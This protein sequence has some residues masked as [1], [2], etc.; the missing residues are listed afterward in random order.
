M[1]T[2]GNGQLHRDAGGRPRRSAGWL[3]RAAVSASG[4]GAIGDGCRVAQPRPPESSLAMSAFRTRQLI[5]TAEMGPKMPLA[6]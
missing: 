5:S 2:S 1:D 3:A 6:S 4:R